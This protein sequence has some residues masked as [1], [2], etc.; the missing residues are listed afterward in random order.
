MWDYG[1]KVKLLNMIGFILIFYSNILFIK[2]FLIGNSK[3]DGIIFLSG[4]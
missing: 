1:S 2:T 3:K 4:G